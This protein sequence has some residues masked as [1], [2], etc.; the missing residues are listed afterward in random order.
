MIPVW[1]LVIKVLQ[2]LS[3]VVNDALTMSGDR[4]CHRCGRCSNLF[5]NRDVETGWYG[6]CLICNADWHHHNVVSSICC[7]SRACSVA[8]PAVCGLRF[9]V[10]LAIQIS[11]Y[12]YPESAET[13][14]IRTMRKRKCRMQLL[15]WT[16]AWY[17]LDGLSD[18]YAQD[19][20]LEAL[21]HHYLCSR[22]H[23]LDHARTLL[24]Y[25]YTFVSPS[26]KIYLRSDYHTQQEEFSWELYHAYGRLWLW[27][28][29]TELWFFVDQPPRN[30]Q[31]YCWFV[32]FP[33]TARSLKCWW[34][35]VDSGH[36]F[37]EPVEPAVQQTLFR[38][39]SAGHLHQN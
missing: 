21:R 36:W 30:W 32:G 37:W 20:P 22:Y 24:E 14:R 26:L 6:W 31:R 28:N 34:Y 38:A 9:S 17:L 8:S 25:V 1:V 4:F 27:N 35:N 39:L 7:C 16:V 12:L 3:R 15:E 2:C 5:G 23:N 18:E 29:D 10:V 11:M 33:R 19:S 13:I